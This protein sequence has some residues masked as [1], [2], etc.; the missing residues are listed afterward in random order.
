VPRACG[1]PGA[2]VRRRVALGWRWLFGWLCAALLAA[3]ALAET[4]DELS[5]RSEGADL[6]A[7]VRFNARVRFL[8]QSPTAR[9][10]L[11]RIT[12]DIVAAD[13]EVLSQVV[14]ESKRLPRMPG[15]PEGELVYVPTP[16]RG[17]KTMTLGL[18]LPGEVQV[19]QGASTRIIDIV[20]V[21]AAAQ[22]APAAPAPAPAPAA[23]ASGV[24]GAAPPIDQSRRFAVRLQRLP[25]A[26]A[27]K[28]ALV[29]RSLERYE[30]FT[31]NSLVDGVATVDVNVGYFATRE[32]AESVRLA[33][34]ER[35]PQA[36]V[37]D[38][39]ERRA[40]ALRSAAV[41]AAA[42]ASAPAAAPAPETAVSGV[43]PAAPQPSAAAPLS[44]G[45]AAIEARAA[46][47]MGKAKAALTE[48]RN[49][50]ASDTLNQLLLLPPNAQSQEAQELIGLASERAGD[51]RRARVEYE[52]YL[53][54]FPEGEGAQRVSQRLASLAP[55]PGAP[56]AAASAAGAPAAGGISPESATTVAAADRR[57]TGNIA[58]YYYGGKAKSQSL[59]NIAAGIDQQTLTRTDESAIVTSVDLGGRF[60]NAE[61]E[62]RMVL[63]GTGST[64]LTSNSH[65]QSV[66]SAAYVDYRRTASG[67]AVRLG[68]QS[69]ISG[70]LLG[71][72]DG[73][74]MTYPVSTGWKFDLMGGVPANPPVSAPQERLLAAVLE[75]D[76][77]F[78]KWGGNVY[79]IDQTTEGID[80]RRA[81]GGELRYSGEVVSTYTLVDYDVLFNKLNAVSLQGS[82]QAPAQTTITFLFD[83]R[84]A[85]SLQV[86]N[87]LI[88]TGATSLKT[89]LETMSIDEVRAAAL[90]TTADAR[91]ALLSVS[92][93]LGEKW[94]VTGDLRWSSIGA[95][96]AVGNFDATPATG[97]QYGATLQLTGSNLYSARDIN[98]FNVSVLN[99]PHFNGWQLGYNN[100]SG[101]RGGD[102]V[103]EPSLRWY[104]QHDDQGLRLNRITPGLRATFRISRRAS[105]LG[106][107][108]VEHST[109]EGPTS[110]D[111]TN[112]VFFYIGYRYDLF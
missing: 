87:A 54:L 85:P 3:P 78:E 88:S 96:P 7:E 112:S 36:T 93:P 15:L 110:H 5:V 9:G 34:L 18:R 70:G 2:A 24:E 61:S 101:L 51:L 42:Q 86:S 80:N 83:A 28:M 31:T 105:I 21:G 41:A 89:L 16:G 59:V 67:I 64:N 103:L 91:Q 6:V 109:T 22:A 17:S 98:N 111:T 81:V 1:G 20:F 102:V 108:I 65:N 52:L 46:E 99:T 76:G 26:D 12:F 50:D 23:P 53:K 97:N 94:Q 84:K 27:D 57:F 37:I 79:L 33:A 68:R 77:I 106:E 45:Q 74:S 90:A 73:V 43:S 60:A 63:R 55:A 100:L 104:T 95:L 48:G 75:A 29:P 49:A 72:F 11:F 39:E 19:R 62:T 82:V 107:G 69:P 56:A 30:A 38:L 10:A 40:E 47:L 14:Q 8:R 66:L 58:Q 32:Q 13:D 35:F 44:P 71:F 92:R 25:L 4:I